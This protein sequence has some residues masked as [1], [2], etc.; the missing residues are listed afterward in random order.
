MVNEARL[1]SQPGGDRLTPHSRLSSKQQSYGT[2]STMSSTHP[3]QITITPNDDP[4]RAAVE[5]L[6][7]SIKSKQLQEA[8]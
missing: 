7:A 3:Q 5:N 8:Q 2:S 4:T 6:I 1:L